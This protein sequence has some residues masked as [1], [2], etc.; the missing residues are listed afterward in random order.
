MIC[1]NETIIKRLQIWVDAGLVKQSIM[2]NSTKNPF[3]LR[4][5][6]YAKTDLIECGI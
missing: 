5:F 6:C 3:N 4:L 2:G 1:I